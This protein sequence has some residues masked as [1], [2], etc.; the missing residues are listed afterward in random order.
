MM[1]SNMAEA[2]SSRDSGK[3]AIP[4]LGRPPPP[5]PASKKSDRKQEDRM[6]VALLHLFGLHT[7][8][9]STTESE[10]VSHAENEVGVPQPTIVLQLCLPKARD[11]MHWR[12]A[13]RQLLGKWHS[14]RIRASSA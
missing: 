11:Q 13:V 5:P 8:T 7:L 4:R 12:H 1:H 3:I 10:L 14:L 9:S 6:Y 2:A